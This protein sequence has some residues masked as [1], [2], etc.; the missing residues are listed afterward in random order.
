L[1]HCKDNEIFRGL[2]D[3]GSAQCVPYEQAYDCI[4]Y[5]T[6]T[7]SCP[8]GY[9]L[10][11]VIMRTCSYHCYIRA[12]GGRCEQRATPP[13]AKNPSGLGCD[14]LEYRCCRFKSA[15]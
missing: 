5:E 8:A 10:N 9:W 7:A 14:Q 11:R 13:T 6:L 1:S 15:P 12:N 2:A 3:D 4:K